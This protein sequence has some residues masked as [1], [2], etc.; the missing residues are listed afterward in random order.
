MASLCLKRLCSIQIFCSCSISLIFK[1]SIW[2]FPF[3]HIAQSTGHRSPPFDIAASYHFLND[4]CAA[5][6]VTFKR[7]IQFLFRFILDN[8]QLLTIE[9]IHPFVRFIRTSGLKNRN[10]RY[11][12]IL[13]QQL[14][15]DESHQ[16]YA[17]WIVHSDVSFVTPGFRATTAAHFQKRK[18]QPRFHM[19]LR[20]GKAPSCV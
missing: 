8:R 14:A 10:L 3:A 19:D 5:N 9:L 20:V 6:V 11:S 1:E 12:V 13:K 17:T 2:I 15:K 4:S 18:P 16:L 7:G